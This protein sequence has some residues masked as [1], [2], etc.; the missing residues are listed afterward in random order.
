MKFFNPSFKEFLEKHPNATMLGMVWAFYWRGIVLIWLL[1]IA[2][3]A[4]SAVVSFIGSF[5]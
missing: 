5:I 3:I 4:I 1:G 2:I